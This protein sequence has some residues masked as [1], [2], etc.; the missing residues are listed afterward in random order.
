MVAHAALGVLGA[1]LPSIFVDCSPTAA[2]FRPR[3][4]P[5]PFLAVHIT[6]LGDSEAPQP[7]QAWQ[8]ALFLARE[9]RVPCAPSRGRLPG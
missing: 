5:A 7:P 4:L 1:A 8:A 6:L 2:P 9:T 3:G